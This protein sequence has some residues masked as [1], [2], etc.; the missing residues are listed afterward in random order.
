MKRFNKISF[1]EWRGY[2]F[3][4]ILWLVILLFTILVGYRQGLS[5]LFILM[6]IILL[7]YSPSYFCNLMLNPRTRHYQP[8]RG[9]GYYR[10]SN[11]TNSILLYMS[12]ALNL[13]ALMLFFFSSVFSWWMLLIGL[14]VA[15]VVPLNTYIQIITTRRE[16]K[17]RMQRLTPLY[18]SRILM[19]EEVILAAHSNVSGHTWSMLEQS[20]SYRSINWMQYENNPEDTPLHLLAVTE[21]EL[22]MCTQKKG[23]A[24]I[25]S[26]IPLTEIRQLYVSSLSYEE[27]LTSSMPKLNNEMLVIGNG[28][29]RQYHFEFPKGLNHTIR[30]FVTQLL[31]CIDEAH[32]RGSGNYVSPERKH[33]AYV[34]FEQVPML[35]ST[36]E[37]YLPFM[38]PSR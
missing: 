28:N 13:L 35:S 10:L 37:I 8:R 24:F 33:S 32:R 38:K 14:A 21:H 36:D 15:S 25:F 1:G 4:S 3:F 12:Y 18:S 19:R 17:R 11:K 26:T 23:K 5:N 6:L 30:P 7:A 31:L 16:M 27:I 20:P 9:F 22:I 34:P 29:Y 2:L